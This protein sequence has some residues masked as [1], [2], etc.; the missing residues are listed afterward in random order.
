MSCRTLLVDPS[1]E[2]FPRGGEETQSTRRHRSWTS[3]HGLEGR[4]FWHTDT[5]WPVAYSL[6]C[7]LFSGYQC[8]S[9]C[10]SIRYENKHEK[11][12][13]CVLSLQASEVSGQYKLSRVSSI[14]NARNETISSILQQSWRQRQAFQEPALRQTVR[15]LVV[16]AV[17][18]R[19]PPSSRAKSD[20]PF[21]A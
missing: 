12:E 10:G 19:V 14:V 6:A 1:L 7:P 20:R 9:I 11:E 17:G 15:A 8:E 5:V 13:I 21:L 3:R 4:R 2:Q 16:V 18:E